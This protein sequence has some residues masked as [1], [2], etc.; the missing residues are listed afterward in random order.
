MKFLNFWFNDVEAGKVIGTDRGVPTNTKVVS[1]LKENANQ[2]DKVVFDFVDQASKN[3]G[4]ALPP[5]PPKD[6]EVI[7]A[8]EEAYWQVI[9][10]MI[11]PEEG[12]KQFRE[13]ANKILAD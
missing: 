11:S 13:A 12:A 1:A 10:E 7:A 9:Y 8:Y 3:S 5:Q 6:Q 4:T 2:Y